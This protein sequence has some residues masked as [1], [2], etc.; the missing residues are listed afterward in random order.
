MVIGNSKG[1]SLLYFRINYSRKKFYNT[2]PG[3]ITYNSYFSSTIGLD[4]IIRQVWKC[5]TV[6]ATQY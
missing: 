1:T 5:V 4:T 3:A 6:T 2:A